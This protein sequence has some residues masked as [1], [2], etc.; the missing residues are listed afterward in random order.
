MRTWR[1]EVG[2]IIQWEV[3]GKTRGKLALVGHAIGEGE[4]TNLHPDFMISIVVNN[5]VD[6]LGDEYESWRHVCMGKSQSCLWERL[7]GRSY[8]EHMLRK[9]A[10]RF[11]SGGHGIPPFSAR[12]GR[13][14]V[15]SFVV[16]GHEWWIPMGILTLATNHIFI[17][18]IDPSHLEP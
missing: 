3:Q 18:H 4:V 17:M 6:N 1:S 8:F 10:G 9:G 14:L 15:H 13:A 2:D 11:K 5:L 16:E 12:E 7:T